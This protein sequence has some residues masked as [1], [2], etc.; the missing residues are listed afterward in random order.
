MCSTIFISF[1]VLLCNLY[2]LARLFVTLFLNYWKC[3]ERQKKQYKKKL[4]RAR[5]AER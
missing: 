5:C 3:D 4:L 1:P 2:V